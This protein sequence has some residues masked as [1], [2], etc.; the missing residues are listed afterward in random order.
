MLNMFLAGALFAIIG[1]EMLNDGK[2]PLGLMIVCLANVSFA[3]R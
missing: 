1:R 2:I 3:Y